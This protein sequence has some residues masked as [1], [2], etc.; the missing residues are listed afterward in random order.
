MSDRGRLEPDPFS[1]PWGH[2]R[3]HA[4]GPVDANSQR[5]QAV[6]NKHYC[7]ILGVYYLD[8]IQSVHVYISYTPSTVGVS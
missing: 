4:T 5:E 2:F 3:G 8:L 6:L 7:G 1:S